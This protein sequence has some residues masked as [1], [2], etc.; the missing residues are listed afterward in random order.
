M[1]ANLFFLKEN[2]HE[3]H[4]VLEHNGKK[5]SYR[6]ALGVVELAIRKGFRS[7]KEVSD[8]LVEE[9][10]RSIEREDVFRNAQMKFDFQ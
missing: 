10:K 1:H 2:I 8:Q 7:T 5:M 4:G 6:I 3:F 9:V